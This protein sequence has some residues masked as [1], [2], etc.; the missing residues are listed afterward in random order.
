M[1][2]ATVGIRCTPPAIRTDQRTLAGYP[3]GPAGLSASRAIR[4]FSASM[5]SR[6]KTNLSEE[7]NLKN[8]LNESRGACIIC[9]KF[10]P[11]YDFGTGAKYSTKEGSPQAF[12]GENSCETA[13]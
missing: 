10:P 9:N 2:S 11:Y 13:F 3:L 6:T 7:S 1:I 4:S 12:W 8:S 5:L